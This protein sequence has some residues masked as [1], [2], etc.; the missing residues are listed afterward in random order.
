MTEQEFADK[1]ERFK[2]T[3]ELDTEERL[4]KQDEIL[5]EMGLPEVI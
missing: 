3:L 4:A 2:A 5:A 1:L